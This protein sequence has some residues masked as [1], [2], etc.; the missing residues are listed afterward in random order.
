MSE[1][2]TRAIE[3]LLM[4]ELPRTGSLIGAIDWH[5][6]GKLML[7]PYGWTATTLPPN[8]AVMR[9]V[10]NGMAR[11]IVESP[12]ESVYRVGGAAELL[13]AAAGGCDDWLYTNATDNRLQRFV[14]TFESRPGSNAGG[15][16]VIPASEILPTGV[17]SYAAAVRF[18]QEVLRPYN[19]DDKVP[20]RY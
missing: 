11:A 12:T 20:T 19:L 1:P 17:E 9:A 14:F 5:S 16:F 18:G 15:G 4:D 3:R 13:G 8:N 6:F 2:E 10:G 7:T